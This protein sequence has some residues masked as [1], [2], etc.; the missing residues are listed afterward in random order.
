MLCM[1]IYTHAKF[2]L[3]FMNNK[4]V[5]YFILHCLL[6]HITHLLPLK[7]PTMLRIRTLLLSIHCSTLYPI[8]QWLLTNCMRF[9]VYK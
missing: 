9:G 4:V 2:A 7:S 8:H 6:F 5:Y 1:P 3:Y